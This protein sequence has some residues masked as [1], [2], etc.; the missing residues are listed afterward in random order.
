MVFV[1]DHIKS[2]IFFEKL[3]HFVGHGRDQYLLI[4]VT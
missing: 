4:F 3:K 2:S 1:Q